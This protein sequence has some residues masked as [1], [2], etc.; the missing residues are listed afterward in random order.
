MT[1]PKTIV[2][3]GAGGMLGYAVV[4]YF[5]RSGARVVALDRR[6]FDISRDPLDKLERLA[7]QASAIVNCAGV[8]KPMIATT[9]VEDVLR[10]NTVFPHNLARL[11]ERLGVR[12]FHVT[13]DCVYTGNRGS[14]DESDYFDADDLYGMSKNGGDSAP[15]MVLRTSIIGEERSTRR[16]LLE[17][18]RSQR[19]KRVSGFVNHRWN[20]VTTVQLAEV[21]HGILE[22][23]LHR[24]GL[25]HIHSPE[26]VTKYE[27]LGLMSDA[28]ELDLDIQAADAPTACDRSLK[29]RFDLSGT[30]CTRS[31]REQLEEMRQFFAQPATDANPHPEHLSRP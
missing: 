31:L 21:I 30:L 6:Q 13:T 23:G 16:S 9:S 26:V 24:V 3:L 15:A 19:G 28:Y 8:I 4:E 7:S 25:F 18:A 12:A 2:V 17:W 14:Y 22:R 11:G 29:S 10:V 27:L 20:G 1:Q 5:T